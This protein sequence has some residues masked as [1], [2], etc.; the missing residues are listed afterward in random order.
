M[1]QKKEGSENETEDIV[2]RV[3]ELKAENGILKILTNNRL[4]C[5]NLNNIKCIDITELLLLCKSCTC[6]TALLVE[7]V[8]E[9]LECD[10]SKSLGLTLNLNMFL[11]FNSLMQTV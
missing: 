7:L 8:K 1:K 11:S 10:S 2:Y 5:R 6:H 9:V 3:R 4:V